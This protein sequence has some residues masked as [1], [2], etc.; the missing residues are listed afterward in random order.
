MMALIALAA[1]FMAEEEEQWLQVLN[2]N[3]PNFK[4]V[5]LAKIPLEQQSSIQVAIVANPSEQQI[6]QLTQLVWVQSL[7]AGVENL[8]KGLSGK[9]VKI[10]PMNDPSLAKDM[11]D[12][13]LLWCMLLQ[14]NTLTYLRQQAQKLWLAHSA[15]PTEKTR[16]GVMGLGKLGARSA[17]RLLQ[18]GFSVS[19]WSRTKK[20][21]VGV[22]SFTGTNE[23]AMFLSSCDILLILLPLTPLTNNLLNNDTLKFLPRTS[24]LINFS[25]GA[26]IDNNALLAS[27]NGHLAHAVLD[28]FETE[29]LP[30]DSPLWTHPK[31]TVLPHISAPTNKLSAAKIVAHN[32]VQYFENQTIP[33][34]IDFNDGY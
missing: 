9:K 18:H 26:I 28:V 4:V 20:K 16:V 15:K 1:Q 17:T 23:L 21:I 30:I 2:R 11:A 13:A 7:W 22:Q 6:S 27:L 5:P 33:E 29:P 19:G 34:Y 10:V 12:S 31:V 24:S 3:L 14:Q 25:R 8:I 32:I